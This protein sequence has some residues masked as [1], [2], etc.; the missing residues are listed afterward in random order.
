M[1]DAGTGG[2]APPPS[3]GGAPSGGGG[4]PPPSAPSAPSG[5]TGSPQG[6]APPPA[7]PAAPSVPDPIR[8]HRFK[9]KADGAERE[10][11]YEEAERLMQQGV[12]ARKAV[13]A[14]A[15]A[16]KEAESA[17]AQ[18]RAIVEAAKSPQH[19]RQLLAR[20]G[21]DVNAIVAQWKADDEALAALSPEQRKEREERDRHETERQRRE[22][23]QQ[24]WHEQ[25][26]KRRG[27]QIQ[28]ALTRDTLAELT[29]AGFKFH[30][31]EHRLA[32]VGRLAPYIRDLVRSGGY[33]IDTAMRAKDTI[34]TAVQLFMEDHGRE[35]SSVRERVLAEI[36]GMDDDAIMEA[37][38][39]EAVEKVRRAILKKHAAAQQPRDAGRFAPKVGNGASKPGE[40]PLT[41]REVIAKYRGGQT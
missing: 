27:E 34:A 29:T 32:T 38:G 35:Q 31:D 41:P 24:E 1:S 17:V 2:G 11:S 20:S 12:G 14:A 30:D 33:G 10:Y 37:L 28:R 40:R 18:A 5:A 39:A 16:R 19:L 6:G 25:D 22:R 23:E 13:E 4:A 21:A 7:P 15:K 26:Q 8:S 3:G 9:V 36:R